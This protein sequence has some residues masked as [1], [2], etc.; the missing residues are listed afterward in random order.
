MA[1]GPGRAVLTACAPPARRPPAR[2]IDR[3]GGA[4]RGGRVV[5]DWCWRQAGRRSGGAGRRPHRSSRGREGRAVASAGPGAS[6]RGRDAAG[7]RDRGGRRRPRQDPRPPRRAVSVP[8]PRH[9]ALESRT[10]ATRRP[11]GVAAQSLGDRRARHGPAPVTNQRWR[12]ASACRSGLVSSRAVAPLCAHRHVDRSAR[13]RPG[14]R[15]RPGAG[16]QRAE[17][18]AAVL[19]QFDPRCALLDDA[20]TRGGPRRVHRA[21]WPI[22]A[23]ASGQQGVDRVDLPARRTGAGQS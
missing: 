11:S 10:G 22:H 1:R 6:R 5:G 4:S 2:W 14:P 8:D 7:T 23:R 17:P 12:A 18:A 16:L 15:G 20:R 21:G 3:V 9:G 19:R 13:P